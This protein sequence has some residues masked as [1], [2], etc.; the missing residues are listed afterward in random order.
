MGLQK[1][2]DDSFET[3]Q[4]SL[5]LSIPMYFSIGWAVD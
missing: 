1:V 4:F 3:G 5:A 2:R